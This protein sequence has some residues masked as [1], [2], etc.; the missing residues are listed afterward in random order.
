MKGDRA[1]GSNTFPLVFGKVPA[2]LLA[3]LLIAFALAVAIKNADP[4]ASSATIVSL[5]FFIFTAIR[6]LD[7]D[8]LRS[9]RYPIFILN[10]FTMAVYPWL[11]IPVFFVFYVSKYYYWHRFDLHYPTFLVD[12]D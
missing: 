7:R 11:F 8:I 5:P 4:L 10:F 1:S 12:N 3:L 9:I 6:R 2:I